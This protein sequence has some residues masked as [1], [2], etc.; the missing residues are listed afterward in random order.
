MSGV[1]LWRGCHWEVG[2]AELALGVLMAG[3]LIQRLFCIHLH[4]RKQTVTSTD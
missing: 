1:L 4:R 2:I 3:W